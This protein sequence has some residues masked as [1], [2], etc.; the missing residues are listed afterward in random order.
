MESCPICLEPLWQGH[1]AF[2]QCG[3]AMCETCFQ[4]LIHREQA[5][6][7]R[8][9]KFIACP[10]CRHLPASRA[11]VLVCLQEPWEHGWKVILIRNSKDEWVLPGGAIKDKD[12]AAS[13][14]DRNAS[15][16]ALQIAAQRELHEETGLWAETADLE[17]IEDM[18]G[19]AYFSWR[20]MVHPDGQSR[21]HEISG[22]FLQGCIWWLG[23]WHHAA[24]YPGVTTESVHIIHKC[25]VKYGWT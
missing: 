21:W 12:W 18:E 2:L 6:H 5:Q 8:R 20:L 13:M 19:Q 1:T 4:I 14:E 16:S 24:T 3:H 9:R 22:C 25:A 11:R 23:S 7:G 10:H 17:H 15:L